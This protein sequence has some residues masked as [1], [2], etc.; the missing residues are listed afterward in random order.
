MMPTLGHSLKKDPALYGPPSL[1]VYIAKNGITQPRQVISH[2]SNT[3]IQNIK[4]YGRLWV[5]QEEALS[6]RTLL[7]S[8]K[9]P[10]WR[11]SNMNMNDANYF[12]Q[13]S[14]ARGINLLSTGMYH[15]A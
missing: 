10:Q 7:F 9:G 4:F 15:K 5:L 12:D 11:C 1:E 13:R 14:S 2:P 8:L 6:P 3:L